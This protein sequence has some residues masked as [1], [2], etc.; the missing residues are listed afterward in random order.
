MQFSFLNVI[1]IEAKLLFSFIQVSNC[2]IIVYEEKTLNFFKKFLFY[3]FFFQRIIEKYK[4]KE[5]E[6]GK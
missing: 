6:K 1:Y 2:F 3:Y 4:K 5:R